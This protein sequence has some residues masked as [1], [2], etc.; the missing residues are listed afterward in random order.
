MS[1][2]LDTRP[3]QRTEPDSE[4]TD[5]RQ[6]PTPEPERAEPPRPAPPEPAPESPA[7]REP[8]P[9]ERD[10]KL[11]ERAADER[12]VPEDPATLDEAT[13]EE[14]EVVDAVPEVEPDRAAEPVDATAD[15]GVDHA[16][17]ADTPDVALPDGDQP[18]AD[19]TAGVEQFD[20][21]EEV[22]TRIETQLE[23]APD[24]G[25]EDKIDDFGGGPSA[26]TEGNGP[27]N[28]DADDPLTQDVRT[29][30]PDLG[31]Y[32]SD[33]F[34]LDV[35]APAAGLPSTG[36]NDKYEVTQHDDGSFYVVD[37]TTGSDEWDFWVTKLPGGK[38]Q[39]DFW[40]TGQK[41][42]HDQDDIQ[43]SYGVDFG[44]PLPA[45]TLDDG[46]QTEM[47]R[48]EMRLHE[49]VDWIFGSGDTSDEPAGDAAPESEFDAPGQID[50]SDPNFQHKVSE[51]DGAITWGDHDSGLDDSET[52]KYDG[53]DYGEEVVDPDIPVEE[54]AD[55]LTGNPLDQPDVDPTR[56]DTND[57][58]LDVE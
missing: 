48:L 37:K 12:E 6:P 42:I 40:N 34:N 38:I 24:N 46:V 18:E 45:E 14:A 10:P 25:V 5:G 33:P 57:A 49:V 50:F 51:R 41:F 11:E 29:D 32:S 16:P 43:I 39:L 9:V 8:A 17:D 54:A 26:P 20:P 36:D 35:D 56:V 21:N 23:N 55:L 3:D 15:A 31:N 53:I 19:P 28:F 27:D 47:D 7:A 4:R 1:D 13:I 2:D 22:A 44:E 30:N 58:F 52:D